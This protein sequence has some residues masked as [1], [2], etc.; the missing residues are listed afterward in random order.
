MQGSDAPTPS[1]FV[2]QCLTDLRPL[3]GSAP[4][5]LDVAI[6]AGRH[7]VVLARFGFRVFGVDRDYERVR[8]ARHR[9]RESGCR[10]EVWVADLESIALPKERFDLVLCTRYLQR[11]LWSCLR[12]AVAPGGFVLYETFTVGQRR[13]D[14]GPRSSAHLLAPGELREAFADWDVWVYEERDAPA[15]EA[16]LLARRPNSD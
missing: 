16:G 13:Y 4:A 9:L 15:A 2:Q 14:W 10:P 5:A 11:T 12:E 8:Q 1:P 6:G 7:A 3:L